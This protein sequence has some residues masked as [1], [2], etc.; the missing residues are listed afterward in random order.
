MGL[1][2]LCFGAG[3]GYQGVLGVLQTT[4]AGIA[5]GALTVWRK[6]LW[7]A[8]AAHLAID[9]V[10]LLALKALQPLLHTLGSLPA[11]H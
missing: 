9:A 7:P 4:G 1:T 2:A 3:H 5:L 8:I 11:T 6:S 10:G